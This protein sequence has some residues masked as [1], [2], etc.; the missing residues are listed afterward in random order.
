MNYKGQE[1]LKDGQCLK[2]GW[3]VMDG[4]QAHF[5]YMLASSHFEVILEDY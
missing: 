3:M 4:V 5:Q 1:I 2:C